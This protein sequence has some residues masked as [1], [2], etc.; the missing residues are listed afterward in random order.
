MNIDSATFDQGEAYRHGGSVYVTS[1]A[2][3]ASN[4]RCTSCT[5]TTNTASNGNGGNYW[6][7]NSQANI[8]FLTALTVTDS[9]AFSTADNSGRGGFLYAT[10]MAIF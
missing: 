9:T 2:G 4:I 1:A 7:D 10:N 6:V 3:A 5:F 8:Y